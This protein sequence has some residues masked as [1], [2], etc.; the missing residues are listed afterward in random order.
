M[1]T[2]PIPM[3]AE[4]MPAFEIDTVGHGRVDLARLKGWRMLVV[5]RG[6]HCGLCTRYLSTLRNL[7]GGFE[8]LGVRV[9]AVSADDADVARQQARDE[10]WPFITGFALDED[11]MRTLGLFVSRADG[12]N[13]PFAEPGVFIVNPQG[14]LQVVDIANAPFSRPDLEALLDGIREIQHSNPPIH[15][16]D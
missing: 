6:R 1:R 11:C 5:Y 7:H 9:I 13:H 4:A 8:A 15:G 2:H 10:G 16:T 12:I 14:Q 3:P